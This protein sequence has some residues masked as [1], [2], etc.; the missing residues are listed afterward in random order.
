[1]KK[2]DQFMNEA[3]LSRI[4]AKVQD[5]QSGAISGYRGDNTRAKNKA[6]NREILA[7]LKNKDYSIVSVKGSYIKNKGSDTEREVGE[8]SFFYALCLP[9][10]T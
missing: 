7:Y 3:S 5:H 4:W 8:P 6:N 1:M 2:L 9:V 10:T